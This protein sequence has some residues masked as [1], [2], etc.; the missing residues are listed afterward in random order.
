MT[1]WQLALE[2]YFGLQPLG[3]YQVADKVYGLNLTNVNNVLHLP[4]AVQV[5]SMVHALYTDV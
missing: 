2:Y 4:Q 1:C 3:I 5:R